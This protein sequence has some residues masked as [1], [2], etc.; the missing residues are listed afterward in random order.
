MSLPVYKPF[1]SSSIQARIQVLNDIPKERA[2]QEEIHP[3]EN[4]LWELF[5]ALTEELG[6]V[7]QA[8]QVHHKTPGTKLT[9][10]AN[11]YEEAIQVSALAARLAERVLVDE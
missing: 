4:T 1:T 7:A 5:G 6:E 11:L 10:K 8:M 3:E 2:R 9:D